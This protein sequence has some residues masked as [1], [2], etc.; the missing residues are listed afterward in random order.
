MDTE[1]LE[2]ADDEDEE[3]VDGKEDDKESEVEEDE[4]AE[5]AAFIA[6]F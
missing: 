3:E 5:G 2:A 1:F 6:G 4:V